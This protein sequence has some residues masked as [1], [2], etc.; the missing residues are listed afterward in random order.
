[1]LYGG[2]DPSELHIK[3][4]F[5]FEKLLATAEAI[6]ST[7]LKDKSKILDIK[8]IPETISAY[9]LLN[10][11][12]EAPHTVV[13][14]MI[15]QGLTI[16]AGDPKVGKSWL[17][18]DLCISICNEEQFLGFNTK[19][20]D[21]S[22]FALEDSWYRLQDRI[23]KVTDI[24]ATLKN[25]HIKLYCNPLNEGLLEELENHLKEFPNTKLIIIDTLQKVRDTRSNGNNAY[26]QDYSEMSK[27]KSFADE[28]KI[29]IVLIHHLKKGKEDNVFDKVNGSI[30]IIGVA[31]TTIVLSKI[32]DK[33]EVLFSIQG[34]DV[35][36]NEKLLSF[37]KATL[38]WEVVCSDLEAKK[39]TDIYNGNPIVKTIKKLLE[40]KPEGLKIKSAELLKKIIETT[41]TK[42]KQE[43]PNAL[44]RYISE[45]LQY[46]LLAFDEI[47]YEPP[48]K[49]GGSSGRFMFFQNLKW[50]NNIYVKIPLLIVIYRY[51]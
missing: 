34:R 28:H 5:N 27:I 48:S 47:H 41:G 12:L 19:K 51:I 1:M 4:V 2:K 8:K 6:D 32:K 24:K 16:L 46:D 30:G 50:I 10:M 21:C 29:C 9:D 49:D 40:E 18:L 22:Y 45:K 17:C 44:T 7:K 20:C 25:F 11:E 36:S 23:N 31:D 35:E 39:D 26:S 15:C 14:D 33:K 3:G 37:N 13:E 38:K 42:P 43:T